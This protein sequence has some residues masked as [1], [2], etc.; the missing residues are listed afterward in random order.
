MLSQSIY[1]TGKRL[2]H[3]IALFA[4][5][6]TLLFQSATVQAIVQEE[7]PIK[8]LPAALPLD[9]K[10]VALGA[11]L[12]REPRLSKGNDV[13]CASCHDFVNAGGADPRPRSIGTGGVVGPVN[14]P[15]VLN[16]RLKFLLLWAGGAES[17]LDQV[18]KVIKNPKVFDTNWEAIVSKIGRDEAYRKLFVDAYGAP[19]DA[20]N[21]ADALVTFEQSLDTDSRF[22]RYLRGD[23]SAITAL[24]KQG[25]ERFKS[26]GCV[27]CH[28][29]AAVGGNMLQKF[30]VLGDYFA[31][32]GNLTAADA[33]RFNVTKQEADRG[34]FVVPSLRNVGLTAPYFHDGSAPT[35]EA[36]IDVMF[37]YQ[38][39]R[40]A[41]T[42]HKAS[43]AAFLRSLSTDPARLR[44]IDALGR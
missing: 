2:C 37:K 1:R 10:R 4:I 35:L 15:T 24:E 25:Y 28:Q 20:L 34:V 6:T 32:R 12:F 7:E 19:P 18:N 23:A 26:Y 22:D 36:A 8:A 41:P 17:L 42:E 30:G 39:G 44:A 16:I 14:S 27:A 31:D 21:I 11:R 33:G 38:L 5:G 29:G 40:P 3:A 13:S 43:I 9:Q